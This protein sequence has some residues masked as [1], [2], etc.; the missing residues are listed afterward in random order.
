MP[1]PDI[2]ALGEI[3]PLP[4]IEAVKNFPYKGIL[5]A[6]DRAP[7]GNSSP[8]FLN[9][10]GHLLRL[11]VGN[12]V[13]GVED[14]TWEEARRISLLKNRAAN[15][16]IKVASIHR[17]GILDRSISIFTAPSMIDPPLEAPREQFVDL[18]NRKLALSERKDIYIY[19][20]GYKVGFENPLLVA[21]EL[22]HFLGYDGVF[23][24]FAWPS[25]PKTLAYA[26]DLET[27]VSSA[28]H[29]KL[30]IEVLGEETQAENIHIVG[31]SAGTR[32]VLNTLFQLALTHDGM[33]KA[34][35]V[36]E[37]RVGHVLLVGSDF[38]RQL[39]GAYLDYGLLN[40]P[41]N[42]TV[43]M[44]GTDRAMGL[45]QW[46]FGRERLGSMWKEGQMPSHVTE[47]L[48]S[49]QDLELIN[50]TAAEGAATGN[51]HAYF[52]QSPWVSSDVLMTL[53]YDLAPENRGLEKI[54]GSVVWTFPED[55]VQ[56][57]L[58]DL[59]EANPD[60]FK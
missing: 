5:Y 43:Y 40:V 56:R 14:F 23:I 39:F 33:E 24:A 46:V 59:K 51:G 53:M 18:I 49:M 41:R 20:H 50:V 10:R 6:T 3:D 21:S 8:F 30:L 22:W 57:F 32:V 28:H 47:V 1:A 31:Y 7:A 34:A 60:L 38:D 17:L 15:Y 44:S 4:E 12:L 9:E 27:A 11:G 35:I 48:E 36:D 45:S 16:P 54:E 52:R 58:E 26:S 2:Y 55:Y 13:L 37:L 19:V 29:L 42:L 25:T